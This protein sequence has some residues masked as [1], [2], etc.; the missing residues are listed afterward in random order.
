MSTI[1]M[2][3]AEARCYA[4]ELMRQHGLTER[5]WSVQFD[6]AKV[7]SGQCNYRQQTISLSRHLLSIRSR[8]ESI[9][10]ITH[11]VAHALVGRGHGHDRVWARKHREL[12]GDGKRVYQMEGID[13]KAPWI[14][15]CGHGKEVAAYHRKPKRLAGWR[16]RCAEGHSDV[17]WEDRR[18]AV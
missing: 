9:N 7:R 10:T 3:Q 17:V 1:V 15:V 14:A 18:L 5:G 16:C 2:T 8:E 6:R 13:P 12:G 4:E 11:E